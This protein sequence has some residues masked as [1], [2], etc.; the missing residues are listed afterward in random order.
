L[1]AKA[2]KDCQRLRFILPTTGVTSFV[3][4]VIFEAHWNCLR[5]SSLSLL[6]SQTSFLPTFR[7]AATLQQHCIGQL[8]RNGIIFIL[9]AIAM[10][11]MWST[12]ILE[13][14]KKEN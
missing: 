3:L 5:Q 4:A 1:R 11:L 9:V 6:I 12:F 13:L 7:F 10:S 8:R 14:S 2:K